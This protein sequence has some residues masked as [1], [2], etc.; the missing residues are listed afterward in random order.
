MSAE[1]FAVARDNILNERGPL[2]GMGLTADQVNA[3]LAVLDAA[4]EGLATPPGD[5]ERWARA[6]A[7]SK[8]LLERAPDGYWT[9][10]HIAQ[11]QLNDA[12]AAQQ[13]GDD[14]THE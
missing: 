13:S 14:Q 3:V 10:W 1:A 6:P 4:F 9:P 5:L 11:E 8:L 12:L 2:E 7:G